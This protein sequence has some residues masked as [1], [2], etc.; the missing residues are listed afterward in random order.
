MPSGMFNAGVAI[1]EFM[2]PLFGS[3]L[4]IE[5]GIN[6]GLTAK[7]HFFYS[8]ILHY[9]VCKEKDLKKGEISV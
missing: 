4:T 5:F 2:G 8:V 7:I 1:A 9:T 3:L 6:R